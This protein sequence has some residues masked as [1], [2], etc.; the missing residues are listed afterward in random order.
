[1]EKITLSDL[2]FNG[3]TDTEKKLRRLMDD[4]RKMQRALNAILGSIEDI[5]AAD[6]S[7][8]SEH[9]L[10][11]LTGLGPEHTVQGLDENMVLISTSAN[12]AKFRKLLLTDLDQT[13]LASPEN[14]DVIT[15]VDGYPTWAPVPPATSEPIDPSTI[16][17]GELAGLADDDHPQ[18]TR[19]VEDEI[20][21]GEWTFRG[22]TLFTD[23]V[24]IFTLLMDGDE[25][26]QDWND[27]NAED[28]ELG[29]RWKVRGD[30]LELYALNSEGDPSETILSVSAVDGV[31]DSI[32]F[33]GADFRYNGDS[34]LTDYSDFT[35]SGSWVF[36]QSV[37]MPAT[38]LNGDEPTITMTDTNAD[39]DELGFE[40]RQR[41]DR[42]E[43]NA[44][45]SDGEVSE[46]A[47]SI[48]AVDGIVEA[49]DFTGN[50][51]R[52]NGAELL[53]TE[54]HA[55]APYYPRQLGYA[56]L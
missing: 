32:D 10:A 29:F 35:I 46:T 12:N 48:S 1:M 19:R 23:T 56:G 52:L 17:H 20:I 8:V 39:S 6:T 33:G 2:Q 31:V 3:Q 53:T 50:E 14:L 28:D 49:I 42:F 26:F 37:T 44:L 24:T 30:R 9:T 5:E 7:G 47:M 11:T 36:S 18:Y 13:D 21:T 25:P 34:V 43:L 40:V 55:E 54:H 4:L 38:V 15:Y 27:D 41:A 16:E 51:I 45:N 22:A